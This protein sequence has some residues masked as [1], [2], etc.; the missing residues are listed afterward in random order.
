MRVRCSI[1]QQMSLKSNHII[2]IRTFKR[3]SSSV[4]ILLCSALSA[5]MRLV[6]LPC[7]TSNFLAA[8]WTR[9]SISLEISLSIPRDDCASYFGRGD[10]I[11]EISGMLFAI[12]CCGD[13]PTMMMLF[14]TR[15]R[16]SNGLPSKRVL[17]M[18]GPH[19]S[20]QRFQ[21]WRWVRCDLVT[22]STIP[23]DKKKT[24]T[25]RSLFA[26]AH[27]RWTYCSSWMCSW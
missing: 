17:V 27:G 15:A 6:M 20:H 19:Q 25:E 21:F 18:W 2:F 5:S 12:D 1:M 16:K 23:S 26:T 11:V 14:M 3:S 13:L 10:A 24:G 22:R 7:R 4:L 8:I 9:S